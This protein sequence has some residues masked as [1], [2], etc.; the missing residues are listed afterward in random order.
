MT[1]TSPACPYCHH[2]V[3]PTEAHPCPTCAAPH[4]EE[5]WN[6]NQGCAVALCASRP[7]L[8]YVPPPE[9]RERLT[10]ALEGSGELA[11]SREAT[12]DGPGAAVSRRRRRRRAA[13]AA[14]A[15]IVVVLVVVVVVA[16]L[17]G[18]QSSPT[19]TDET[20]PASTSSAL[21]APAHGG[22][23]GDALRPADGRA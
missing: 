13:I 14:G 17:A 4:H 5:C 8:P 18:S 20:I 15:I 21:P 22:L 19:V 16:V 2:P 9:R 7:T 1:T 12:T 23:R 10:V 11:A 6:E 3:P